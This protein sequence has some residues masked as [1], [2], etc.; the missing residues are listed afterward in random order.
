MPK[1]SVNGGPSNAG[2]SL[3]KPPDSSVAAA[4][5]V[6]A[7]AVAKANA[8]AAA[9]AAGVPPMPGWTWA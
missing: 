6:A 5:A 1:I 9:K 7:H 3:P 2:D 4:A 8:A